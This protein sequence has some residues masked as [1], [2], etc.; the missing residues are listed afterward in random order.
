MKSWIDRAILRTTKKQ[1]WIVHG[2]K[3]LMKQLPKKYHRKTDDWD[4]WAKQ[5]KKASVLME[6]VLEKRQKGD[7]FRNA[8]LNVGN[9]SKYVYRVIE[10]DTGK[11][12]ADFM[13][14]PS[15]S[16]YYVV[17]GGIRWETLAHAKRKYK[18]ILANPEYRYRHEKA[19]GDLDRILKF[20]NE[21]GTKGAVHK[22]T[23][24]SV[25]YI[26]DIMKHKNPSW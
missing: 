8:K 14:S 9:T 6:S 10:K 25:S 7:Q 2:S 18:E 22:S 11:S 17:I 5:P 12:V 26:L 16:G 24:S 15:G 1:K 20:E 13:A 19:R 23:M 3:A 21:A 4:L